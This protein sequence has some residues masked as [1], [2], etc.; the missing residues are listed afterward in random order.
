M[1][2]ESDIVHTFCFTIYSSYICLT[3]YST[4]SLQALAKMPPVQQPGGELSLIPIEKLIQV[5]DIKSQGS[6]SGNY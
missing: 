6:S 1:H 5:E 2:I 3:Y 4:F